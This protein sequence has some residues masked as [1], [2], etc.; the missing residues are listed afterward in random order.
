MEDIKTEMS[1][2]QL[3]MGLKL[4]REF[5]IREVSAESQQPYDCIE[6]HGNGLTYTGKEDKKMRG[7]L[8]PS[9]RKALHLETDGKGNSDRGL[10]P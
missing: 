8:M 1:I 3:D 5:W 7:E 6:N 2:R 9:P 4:R 10:S